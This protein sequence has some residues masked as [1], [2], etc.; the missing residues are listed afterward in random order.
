MTTALG[1]A[2][3]RGLAAVRLLVFVPLIAIVVSHDLCSP[4]AGEKSKSRTR[5]AAIMWRIDCLL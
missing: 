1:V 5:I 4:S 2:I 3:G